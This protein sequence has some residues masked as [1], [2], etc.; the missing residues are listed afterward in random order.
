MVV[1]YPVVS[2][3][4]S[5]GGGSI[6]LCS[7]CLRGLAAFVDGWAGKPMP[8]AFGSCGEC[9]QCLPDPTDDEP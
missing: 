1:T 5:G 2:I 8:D 6:D 7:V 3:L 9:G 4:L